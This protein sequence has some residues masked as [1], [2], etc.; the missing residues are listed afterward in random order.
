M[1][2][3][4]AILVMVE[5][6][7]PRLDCQLHNETTSGVNS[8]IIAG[9]NDW[10][11]AAGIC[12]SKMPGMSERLVK[13]CAHRLMVLPCCSYVAQ[14]N[15]VGMHNR[16]SATTAFQSCDVIGLLAA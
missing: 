15:V 12:Q 4:S 10:N 13:F 11:H 9:L 7:L 2:S 8:A 16:I 6:S 14:K 5:G 3:P 1:K